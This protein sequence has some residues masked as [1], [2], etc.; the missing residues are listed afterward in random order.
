MA[1]AVA[2]TDIESSPMAARS[3]PPGATLFTSLAGDAIGIVVENRYADPRMWQE[4]FDE[5]KF[6]SMGTGV[7]VGDYDGDGKPDVFVVSKTEESRLFRNLGGWKFAD[8]TAKAGIVEPGK[9]AAWTQ[10]AAFADVN[11]DGRLDLYLCRFNS[12]NLLFVNQGDGTFKEE[13]QARGLAVVDASVMGAF[14]DYDRDGWL[15]VYV[16]TN[17]LDAVKAPTGQKDYLYRNRGDGTFEDVTARAGIAGETMGHSA[18]WWDYDAD[19]WPDLYVANDFAP[20]D[21]LYRNNRDGTFAN[22]IDHAVEQM[23]H[24]AMG[25]DLGDVDNDGWTDLLVSDMAA[26]TREKDQR[27]VA[28]IRALLDTIPDDPDAP[29]QFMRSTLLLGTGTSWL[30]E[31]AHYA[32]VAATDWTWSVRFEDFDNDGRLDLH[33]TNGMVRELHNADLVQDISAAESR[34]AALRLERAAPVF[35]ETNLA[36]RNDGEGRFRE[37]G[38]EWGLDERGVSFGAATGDLDGDGDMDLIYGNFESGPTVLRNDSISGHRIVVAL[39]GTR[40]NRFG[41]GA[42]VRLESASR[43]QMRTLMLARG[44]LSTSEPILH[45]GLGE[46]QVIEKLTVEWPS[47][48]LQQ[49][50]NVPVDQKFTITEPAGSP[51]MLSTSASTNAMFE[52]EPTELFVPERSEPETNLQPLIPFRFDRRGPALAAFPDETEGGLLL[53][54]TT[55]NPLPGFMA[56]SLDD[57]PLLIFEANGDGRPDLLQTKAGISRAFGADYQPKLHL[58]TANGYAAAALPPIPQSTGAVCA[59]DYDRD[60]DIDVFFGARVLPGKYPLSPRSTLLRN[61]GGIFKEVP[62]PRNGELGMVTSAEW[63]DLDQDGWSDLVATTEWGTVVFLRNDR[64]AGFSDGSAEQG[65]TELGLWTSLVSADFNRDGKPDYAVGNVGLNTPYQ[66]GPAIL[67][68]GRFGDGGPPMM[69][70]AVQE[71]NLLYARRSRNEL[72][73]RVTG[74][75]RRFPRHNAY[76]I[77]PLPEVLG[78]NRL[79]QARRFEAREMR[80]GIYLSQSDGT[81]RFE[82]LPWEA[83]LSPL[84]GMVALDL[85]GDGAPDVAAVQ[86]SHAPTPSLGRFSGGLGVVLVNDGHGHFRALAPL[87][88]GFV[89]PGDGKALV[90]MDFNQDG[91]PDLVASRNNETALRFR[92]GQPVDLRP[93]RVTL[94]GPPGNPT[95]IGA[96]LTVTYADGSTHSAEICAGSGYYSQSAPA[97]FFS[98]SSPPRSLAVRWPD[99]ST[100]QHDLTA[101]SSPFVVIRQP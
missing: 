23:P 19:G 101:N 98:S 46:D 91:W 67:F 25:S 52:A 34:A 99:G 20:P 14:C 35:A 82:A 58:G 42:T 76:A 38:R 89:V 56:D 63:S 37:V 73:L 64:G 10:G 54:G 62:L 6:G 47:G 48:H 50:T 11:N 33:V 78:A 26:T 53:G 43:K 9:P 80:S 51:K 12:P 28:K 55:Q 88:S 66:A 97:A 65:F 4:K 40:S 3:G 83:Q 84:Q 49:F 30:R 7:T 41:I 8:V 57:G 74:L 70:E 95:G 79:A 86:N 59:A 71:N 1:R 87:A 96:H 90:A 32:G 100:S 13:G 29:L 92:H 16:Q 27:G 5:F 61:D 75:L 81:H 21:C 69:I 68:H 44:Y 24:S 72:G 94:Q 60:G 15:D 36:Y 45:F 77:A 39:R 17:L 85:T 22:V 93:L 18:T 2:G 31:S